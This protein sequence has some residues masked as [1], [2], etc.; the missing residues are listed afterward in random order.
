MINHKCNGG[1]C[2]GSCKESKPT[3][4]ATVNASAAYAYYS[5][6]LNKPFD[7]I[8]ELQE[9][10]NAY[11][12]EQRAKEAAAN[13]KTAD[14][15]K[16]EE[17]FKAL[18]AARKEY[19]EKLE[20]LTDEYSEALA[21]LKKA[22][23]AGRVDLQAKLTAAE[24]TYAKALKDFTAKYSEYDLTMEDGDTKAVISGQTKT[25]NNKKVD[26]SLQSLFDLLFNF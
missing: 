16:V 10:E 11:Y 6:V 24:D 14:A 5:R 26:N 7:S 9:A 8:A 4:K 22:F 18:N 12:A 1:A 21:N 17:A 13:S 20:Q 15:K 25:A 23:E 3:K 2:D 19:R